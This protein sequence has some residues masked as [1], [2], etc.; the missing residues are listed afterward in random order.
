MSLDV[1]EQGVALRDAMAVLNCSTADPRWM[2]KFYNAAIS[3]T[4]LLVWVPSNL[5]KIQKITK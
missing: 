2:L 5:F 3:A 1:G 4:I